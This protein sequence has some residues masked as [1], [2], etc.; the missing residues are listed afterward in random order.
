MGAFPRIG[1]IDNYPRLFFQDSV[2]YYRPNVNGIF[3]EYRKGDNNAN[4]WLD[5]TGRQSKTVNEEFFIGFSGRFKTGIFY[6]QHFGAMFHYAGKMDP[7]VEEP[8]HDNLLFL[9]SAGID[10]SD[11]TGFSKL[12]TNAGWATRMERSRADNS[13]WISSNGLMMETRVEYKWFGL[14][15]TFFSGNDMMH[16]YNVLGNKLYWGDPTYRSKV[17]D[18]SDFYIRFLQSR[19]VDLE[20]TYSLTF[21]EGRMYNEQM[22]KININLNSLKN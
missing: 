11:G 6:L 17:S 5:W 20:F 4:V 18:R 14:F 1:T 13:G 21:M 15:N 19:T 12:E 3:W 22:L 7:V 8:L 16:Y 9:T 2:L 10:L